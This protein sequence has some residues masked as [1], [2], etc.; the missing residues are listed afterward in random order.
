MNKKILLFFFSYLLCSIGGVLYAQVGI[1]TESPYRL[2]ELHIKNIVEG[3]DTIP[4]GIM[5]PRMTEKQREAIVVGDADSTNSLMI[6]NID[7]D[8]YNYYSKI[9]G[10][11]KSLCGKLGRAQFEISN[12]SSIKVFGQYLNGEA[13]TTGNFI[14]L[15]VKVTKPGAYT[16]TA[17]PDPDNGY[18][19]IDSGEFLTTG[20]YNIIL[21]GMGT[22]TNH[23]NEGDLGDEIKF[24][25]NGIESQ[26]TTHIFVEDSSVKPK[27]SIDCRFVQV[28]GVY[29]INQPLDATK[30]TITLVIDVESDADGATY[31]ITTT[32][33]DGI[34]FEG[35][36][37]LSGGTRQTVTLLPVAGATPISSGTKEI[38]IQTNSESSNATCTA[39]INVGYSKKK[40]LT[41]SD[42]WDSYGF[43][44]GP[45]GSEPSGHSGGS[46]KLLLKD[47][48]FGMLE[49]SKV[50]VENIEIIGRDAAD[51]DGLSEADF[52]NLIESNNIN[53]IHFSVRYNPPQSHC[54][55]LLDFMKKGG[56]VIA[57]M[58]NHDGSSGAYAQTLLTT[59]FN[60]NS[61]TVGSVNAAGAVYRFQN[62]DDEIMNGPFGSLKGRHWGE[63]SSKSLAATNLP[64]N[65]IIL[66]TTAEDITQGAASDLYEGPVTMFRH[67]T[68]PF[69]WIGDGGFLAANNAT[70]KT[71]CPFKIDQTTYLPIPK[72]FGRGSGARENIQAYNSLVWA[73][74]MAWAVK[75][76]QY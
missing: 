51:A 20:E 4:K 61:I 53:I 18:Y 36:G 32:T 29:V 63:D 47:T 34:A 41:L 67:R 38:V 49:N 45:W 43:G 69:V 15:T 1:N 62:V 23:H 65:D 10:E 76:A 72:R 30:N 5:I 22:P 68:L 73:N 25:L 26:C 13:L 66:Y 11:W 58:D 27:Y 70:S 17:Q 9:D 21:K 8:C 42:H 16:I 12:C 57:M 19:F 6:Y 54:N 64:E 3:T 56:V 46:R 60:D 35:K 50:I 44:P 59:V 14:T 71:A 39:K 48:N 40:L 2:T 33:V 75:T 7:E 24:H 31:I 74:V 37:K 52:R 28:N 55:V